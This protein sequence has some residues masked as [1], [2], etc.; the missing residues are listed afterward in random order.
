MAEGCEF[1]LNYI[2]ERIIAV[3]FDQTC[4]E[5]TYLHNLH[6]ITQMLQSKHSDNYMVRT[7]NFIQTPYF[8]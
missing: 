1:D 8:K 7:N 2:T 6:N 3:S 5:K 4:P